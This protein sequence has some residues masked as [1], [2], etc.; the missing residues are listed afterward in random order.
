MYKH[1]FLIKH[2]HSYQIQANKQVKPDKKNYYRTESTDKVFIGVF[3]RI[4]YKEAV[5]KWEQNNK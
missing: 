5:K 3:K 1:V 4:E 2:N